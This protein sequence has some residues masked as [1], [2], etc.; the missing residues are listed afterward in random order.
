MPKPKADDVALAK[1]L[2]ALASSHPNDPEAIHSLADAM[3]CDKLITL[4]Y[5]R[6]VDAF[7]ALP[8]FYA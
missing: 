1:A 8:K 5:V 4:G 6:S 7:H 2:T 3:L